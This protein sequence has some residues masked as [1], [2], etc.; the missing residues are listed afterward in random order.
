MDHVTVVSELMAKK[1]QITLAQLNPTVGD[2]EGNVRLPTGGGRR[3]GDRVAHAGRS[4][5]VLGQVL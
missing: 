4:V 2:L 1:F 3:R 5:R